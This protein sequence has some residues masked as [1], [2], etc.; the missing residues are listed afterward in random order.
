MSELATDLSPR[1][2]KRIRRMADA[3]FT[4]GLIA[5]EL[6]LPVAAVRK[7]LHD[8]GVTHGTLPKRC[9]EC[10]GLVAMPCRA[11]RLRKQLAALAAGDAA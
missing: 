5:H 4:P 1:T 3:L 11:C 8:Y 9:P 7:V 2:A 10:G 6:E